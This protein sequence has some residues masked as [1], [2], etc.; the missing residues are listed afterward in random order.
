MC[1]FLLSF[2]LSSGFFTLLFLTYV[3]KTDRLS[4]LSAF[5]IEIFASNRIAIVFFE[6]SFP[7]N[8]F[9]QSSSRNEYVPACQDTASSPTKK[10]GWT[11]GMCD[12]CK[13]TK[14]MRVARFVRLAEKRDKDTSCVYHTALFFTVYMGLS[15]KGYLWVS[16]DRFTTNRIC[17]GK[18]ASN[19]DDSV[20]F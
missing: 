7:N 10:L 4:S 1:A 14:L 12:Q 17:W 9:L 8:S 3:S 11:I 5:V 6:A 13:T 19:C 20:R 15:K 2:A 18:M 16:L